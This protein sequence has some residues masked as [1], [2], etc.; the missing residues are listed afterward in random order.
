MPRSFIRKRQRAV[1][2]R[3]MEN[4]LEQDEAGRPGPRFTLRKG[5]IIVIIVIKRW[6]T[7][8]KN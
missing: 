4:G 8:E 7:L 3:E 2:R 6:C 1:E 5:C